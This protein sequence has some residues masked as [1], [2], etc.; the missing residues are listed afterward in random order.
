MSRNKYPEETYQLILD[1]AFQLFLEKGYEKTSLQDIIDGLG[2][3]TKGAIYHHFKSKE[4]ILMKVVEHLCQ[5][6][7]NLMTA[8]RD[9]ETLTGKERIEKMYRVSL[10]NPSQD[11]MFSMVPN[12]LD[13]PTFLAYYVKQLVAITIPEFIVPLMKIGVEDGSI[14]TKYPEELGDA[15]MILTDVWLNPLVF[16]MTTK[17]LTRRAMFLA[18]LFEPYGLKIFSEEQIET[19]KRCQYKTEQ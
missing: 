9:D 19:L 11:T 6:N 4:E 15:L 10:G 2:G 3:L 18:E 17:Q 1:T 5:N 16:R 14:K 13:N 12:L 7:E 8:I